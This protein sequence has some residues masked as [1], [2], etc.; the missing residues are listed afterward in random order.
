MSSVASTETTSVAAATSGAFR[1]T[2][3]GYVVRKDA[4]SASQ[5]DRVRKDLFVVPVNAVRDKMLAERKRWDPTA[6]A[7]ADDGFKVYRENAAKL[8]LPPFY[9]IATFGAPVTNDLKTRGDPIDLLFHGSLRAPQEAVAEKTV[10][11]LDAYGGGIL[12]LR[13]GFG[14]TII[15]LNLFARLGVKVLV[16]VHKEFLMNQ[17]RE[18]IAEFLPD[19]RVGTLQAKVC[20]VDDRDIVIGM[21]QS[22][23]VGKYPESTYDGF[24]MC[25]FDECHHLGAAVFS[26][27]MD[28][29]RTRYMLGLSATPDRKDGLRKVFDWQLGDVICKVESK[30]TQHVYVEV[31]K[32]ADPDVHPGPT[33]APVFPVNGR[34]TMYREQPSFRAKLLAFVVESVPRLDELL[35]VVFGYAADPNRRV[36][37]LSERRKHLEAIGARLTEAKVEHGY[38]WGGAKQSA[39]EEAATKQ[40]LLGTYHMASEGMDVPALN[41]VVLASP[42]S[43]VK[44]SV[45]RILRKT[46]HPVVPTVVDFVDATLPCFARQLNVRKRFYQASGFSYS[47]EAPNTREG[48]EAEGGDASE[49]GCAKDGDGC[50]TGGGSGAPALSKNVFLFR[51]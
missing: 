28:I 5:L 10:A 41:T 27:A 8:Y 50:G 9:G 29:G 36:L 42:K 2:R 45:G 22:V 4:L 19:A 32:Y 7:D 46:D 15:A 3:R 48:G 30:V 14:K 13:C 18:R 39:L 49:G 12:Q 37:V 24:G 44:Q 20:D 47:K 6:T 11:H 35:A 38:Y 21:L 40:V 33:G 26:R 31:H 23:A 25:C 43:D 17:W 34:P 51:S 1:L 16:L